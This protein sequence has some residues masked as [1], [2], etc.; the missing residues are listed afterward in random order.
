MMDNFS[1]ETGYK[2]TATVK[3]PD[4]TAIVAVRR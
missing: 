3:Y 1:S 2:N 4:Q